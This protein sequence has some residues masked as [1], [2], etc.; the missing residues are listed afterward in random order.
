GF[1]RGARGGGGRTAS[2]RHFPDEFNAVNLEQRRQEILNDITDT[3]AQ[4]VLGLTVGC[5][6]CHDHKFDPIPQADYYRLQAFF[7]AYQPADIPAGRHEEMEH[8][9]AELRAWE[10]KTAELRK[11]MVELEGPYRQKFLDSRKKRFPREYQEMFD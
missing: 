6:K 1:Y 5:A 8:Y 3:T 7:A 10:E 9:R 2:H 4:V 11:Q